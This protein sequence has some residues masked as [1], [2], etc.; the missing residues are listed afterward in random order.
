MADLIPDDVVQ[1]LQAE[2]ARAHRKHGSMSLLGDD[3]RPLG[4]IG[5]LIEEVGEVAKELTYDGQTE[6]GLEKELIQ[7]ANVALSWVTWLRRNR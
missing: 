4:R 2:A 1:D 6:G 7:T 5:A 3:L